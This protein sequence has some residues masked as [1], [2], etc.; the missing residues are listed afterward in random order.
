MFPE[1]QIEQRVQG[2]HLWNR[3]KDGDHFLPPERHS[4]CGAMGKKVDFLSLDVAFQF[5]DICKLFL[6]HVSIL[7]EQALV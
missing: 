7:R 2:I 4:L 6:M 5:T 1:A 3:E